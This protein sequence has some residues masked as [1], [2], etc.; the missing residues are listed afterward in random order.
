[1]NPPSTF[2][3]LCQYVGG[4]H[5]YELST[6]SSDIDK[7]GVFMHSDPLWRYGFYSSDNLTNVTSDQDVA[8]HELRKFLELCT[9]SNT[10]TL[11][12]LFAPLSAFDLLDEDF[13]EMIL[14]NR[15]KLINSEQLYKSLR[16][17]LQNELRLAVGERT[18]KTGSKRKESLALH[19]FSPKNF[20]HLFRLTTSG[21]IFFETGEFPVSIKDHRPSAHALCLDVKT[22]PGNYN[23]D[24]LRNEVDLYTS[25]FEEA[26]S[27]SKVS[28]TPDLELVGRILKY[29]N[30]RNVN[31]PTA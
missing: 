31:S 21:T 25:E 14:K 13:Q 20:S 1:M 11:E 4:S 27:N 15:L 8:L 29:F 16:G 28:Y 6:A 7:R 2:E 17:Y 10:Q 30:E 5:L 22:N 26:Y 3:H 23:V 12:C 24:S 18:G 19:G 9:K